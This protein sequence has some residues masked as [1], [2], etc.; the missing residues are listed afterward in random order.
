SDDEVALVF[1]PETLRPTSEPPVNMRHATERLARPGTVAAQFAAKLL[2]AA[3]RLFYPERSYPR[4]LHDAG[5][6]DRTIAKQLA[7]MLAS[8][9]LKRE[10]AMTLLE[11]LSRE[12]A[13]EASPGPARAH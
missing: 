12:G 3:K 7:S 9:D 2:G 11:Q 5:I 6:E 10:D 4:I 13:G 8:Y 1:D